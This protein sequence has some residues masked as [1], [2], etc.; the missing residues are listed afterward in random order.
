MLGGEPPGRH[1]HLNAHFPSFES[2]T[3]G[4]ESGIPG[5]DV[6]RF[7]PL[8]ATR[9]LEATLPRRPPLPTLF[10]Q[11]R[12]PQPGSAAAPVA[13]V[14][15]AAAAKAVGAARPAHRS[16]SARQAPSGAPASLRARSLPAQ[17]TAPSP[18]PDPGN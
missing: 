10:Q 12:S 18:R 16:L 9:P 6:A 15:A 17:G 2:P 8:S 7:P 14:A 1:P 5:M 13:T 3:A 4:A 11:P